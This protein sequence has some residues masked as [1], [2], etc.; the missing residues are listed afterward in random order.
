M[1]ETWGMARIRRHATRQHLPAVP[2][3]WSCFI[4]IT[5][6]PRASSPRWRPWLPRINTTLC[7]VP[8]SLVPAPSG[9]AC[10][11]T[12]IL[13]NRALTFGQNILVGQK[14]SEYHTGYRAWRRTVLER[15]PLAACSN[16]FVFDNQML[17]QAIHFGFRIGE[18]SCP[19]KYFPEASSINFSRSVTYGI[20]VISTSCAFRLHRLGLKRSPLFMDDGEYRLMS[21]AHRAGR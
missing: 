21:L 1:T 10:R 6:I 4:P 12:S 14:L 7:L 15:L 9:G 3:S 11:G 17:V 16:D 13:R 2:T 20:G 5:N 18:I 19:T 8:A